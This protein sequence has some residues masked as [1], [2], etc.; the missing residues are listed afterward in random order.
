MTLKSERGSSPSD[1]IIGL[2][3][4]RSIS[5]NSI[6]SY[7]RG[8]QGEKDSGNN[9][10]FLGCCPSC[11]YIRKSVMLSRFSKDPPTFFYI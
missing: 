4:L 3:P 5:K 8:I 11:F 10:N 9:G 1:Y 6:N 2:G 7:N